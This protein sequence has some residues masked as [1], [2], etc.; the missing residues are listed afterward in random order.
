MEGGQNSRALLLEAVQALYHHPDPEI[1]KSADRWLED[2]QYTMDA[3]QV[4]FSLPASPFPLTLLSLPTLLL[5]EPFFVAWTPLCASLCTMRALPASVPRLLP[6]IFVFTNYVFRII[7]SGSLLHSADFL[8]LSFFCGGKFRGFD[9]SFLSLYDP[10]RL[11]L[12]LSY[13]RR[14]LRG[15]SCLSSRKESFSSWWMFLIL[16]SF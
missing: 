1:R 13:S 15:F 8:F 10:C 16:C 9:V 14:S 11:T 2:F 7:R 3:W 4:T 6:L 5:F 12:E